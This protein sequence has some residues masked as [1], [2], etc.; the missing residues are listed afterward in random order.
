VLK[1]I[2]AQHGLLVERA[3]GIYSFSHLTF[4]EY[5]AA[6]HISNRTP[7]L[8][9]ALKQLAI[10]ISEKRYREIF[11]LTVG[12]LSEADDLLMSMKHQIDFLLAD[13]L[14]LQKMLAWTTQKAYS[15]EVPY[16]LSTVRAFYFALG[17]DLD[18]LFRDFDL[19]CD[20]A[21]TRLSDITF[22]FPL[23]IPLAHAQDIL[24]ERELILNRGRDFLLARL[25]DRDLARATKEA[26]VSDPELKLKLEALKAKLPSGQDREAFKQWWATQ[27]EEWVNQLRTVMIE[28]RNI[29]HDWQFTEE[30]KAKLQQ[31][32]D[33]NKLLVDC[34]NSDCYVT[35]ATRQYIEDT[36]LLP[37]SEIEKYEKPEIN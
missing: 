26:A 23:D 29:G 17:R 6:R 22:Y 13:D 33:A 21:R 34:L 12:I 32:Y 5:F 24:L 10:H 30:Q 11:L 31:Y 19:V 18:D 1:S 25:L 37:M 15:V 35:K 27:G 3:R 9:A 36:L 2:E 14:D 28:H 4:Q 20:L 16:K 8:H 7:Q